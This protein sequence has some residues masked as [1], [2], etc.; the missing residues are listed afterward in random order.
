MIAF[1][2]WFGVEP[3]APRIRLD[4]DVEMVL[5]TGARRESIWAT[6]DDQDRMKRLIVQTRSQG[7]GRP[8]FTRLFT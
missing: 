8:R 6:Y 2:R 5:I 7:R 4:L 3:S 1:R